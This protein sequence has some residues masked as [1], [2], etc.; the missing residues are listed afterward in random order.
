MTS[1]HDDLV[2]DLGAHA[3]T[4]IR[5]MTLFPREGRY[6]LLLMS[7]GRMQ[8]GER[9][10]CAIGDEM[11]E[12]VLNLLEDLLGSSV[13]V[14]APELETRWL[15]IPD[16]LAAFLPST[17]LLS[18]TA[19]PT[20]DTLCISSPSETGMPPIEPY[21]INTSYFKWLTMKL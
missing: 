1:Q 16:Y 19:W 8:A 2:I 11:P 15:A 6:A 3:F 17:G 5:L 20:G 21:Y 18:V 9:A 13:E 12:D 4:G 10:Y 7:P 14:G